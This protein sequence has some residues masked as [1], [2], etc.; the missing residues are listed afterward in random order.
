MSEYLE[1]AEFKQYSQRVDAENAFQ[2]KRIEKLEQTVE[3]ITKLTIS[4]EK[5]AISTEMMANELKAQ[6]ARLSEIENKPAKNWDKLIWIIV[7]AVVGIALGA[8]AMFLG[9]K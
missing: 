9:L 4:V 8:F 1:M 6:G 7:T 3:Q 5:M 2:N